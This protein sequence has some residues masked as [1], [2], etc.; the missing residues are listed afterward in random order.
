VLKSCQDMK[1][2]LD[3]IAEVFRWAS[4]LLLPP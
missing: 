3:A 1:A 4:Q 2:H